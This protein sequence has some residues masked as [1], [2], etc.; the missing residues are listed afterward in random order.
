MAI[1]D[2]IQF[3]RKCDDALNSAECHQLRVEQS[4]LETCDSPE[5]DQEYQ[6]ELQESQLVRDLKA[7]ALH[8]QEEAART[9]DDF[10][11]I[12]EKWNKN[13]SNRERRERYNEILRGDVPIDY[14]CSYSP[15]LKIFPEYMNTAA[16]RQLAKGDFLDFIYDCPFEM[17]DLTSIRYAK[18]IVSSL[19][20]EHKEILYFC[21]VKGFKIKKVAEMRGQSDR[22][23]RRAR[24]VVYNEV[25]RRVYNVLSRRQKNGMVLSDRE[26]LFMRGYEEG[27]LVIDDDK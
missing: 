5:D 13:D 24:R 6:K 12:I 14:G 19:K 4:Y 22:N 20:D 21:G 18:D 17:H 26:R 11:K 7:A 2:T 27:T 25:W 9:E 8:R 1:E 15:D 3:N 10:K 23:I 16:E